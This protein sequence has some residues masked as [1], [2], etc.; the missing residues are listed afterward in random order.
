MAVS[1][2]SGKTW[3]DFTS[4]AT[5]PGMER[6]ARVVDTEPAGFV[7]EGEN[8]SPGQVPDNAM[9][10]IV[11]STRPNVNFLEGEV[12]IDYRRWFTPNLWASESERQEITQAVHV[13]PTA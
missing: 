8:T 3:E 11:C 2:D 12:R 5:S 4:L 13:L 10:G 9:G 7:R 1:R 6:V